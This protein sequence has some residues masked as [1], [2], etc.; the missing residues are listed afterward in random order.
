MVQDALI[1]VAVDQRIVYG[2]ARVRDL[3]GSARTGVDGQPLERLVPSQLPA[4]KE[5]FVR[6]RRDVRREVASGT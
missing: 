4:I 6:G 1:L 5:S 3:D 2:I